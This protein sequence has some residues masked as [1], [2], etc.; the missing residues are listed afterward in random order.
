MRFQQVAG[1]KDRLRYEHHQQH[2]PEPPVPRT[3]D[4][5]PGQPEQRPERPERAHQNRAPLRSAGRRT[6]HLAGSGR[7]TLDP[8]GTLQRRRACRRASYRAAARAIQPTARRGTAATAPPLAR[9]TPAAHAPGPRPPAPDQQPD[10]EGRRCQQHAPMVGQAE[11]E[12][13]G[14]QRQPAGRRVGPPAQ[15]AAPAPAPGTARSGCTCRRARPGT[16][17]SSPRPRLSAGHRRCRPAQP[18]LAAQPDDG[19]D[20]ARRDQCVQQVEAVGH[21]AERYEAPDEVE[22]HLERIAGRVGQ[23]EDR[24]DELEARRRRRRG[25]RARASAG[26]PRTTPARHPRQG[27]DHQPTSRRRAGRSADSR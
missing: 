8:A 21:A 7:R 13:E 6:P 20:R 5:E 4:P 15:T 18:D 25:R 9:A 17:R 23:P 22:Q 26:T 3:R 11:P 27:R 12:R 2:Q 24:R 14:E 1:S 16:T 19:P 10:P